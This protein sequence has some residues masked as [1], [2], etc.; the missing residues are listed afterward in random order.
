MSHAAT[1]EPGALS[2]SLKGMRLSNACTQYGARTL[3]RPYERLRAFWQFLIILWQ[4][5]K[6][7]THGGVWE[8]D[9]GWATERRRE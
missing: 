3:R 9:N 8:I 1:P 5:V 6:W 4:Q 7:R 2:I